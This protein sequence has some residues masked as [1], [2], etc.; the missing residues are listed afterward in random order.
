MA[1]FRSGKT[2]HLLATDLASRG[3]DI[4]NVLTVINYEAP[5]SHE[6]YLHRVGRTARAGL[7]ARPCPGGQSDGDG[8]KNDAVNKPGALAAGVNI[9]L[10]C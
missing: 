6:I 10:H 2:T 9:A 4:K 5:Q 8:Q 7:P 3:L 1:S